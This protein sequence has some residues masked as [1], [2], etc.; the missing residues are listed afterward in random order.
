VLF[1]ALGLRRCC[2]RHSRSD[3]SDVPPCRLLAPSCA[4]LQVRTRVPPR[5]QTGGP[6]RW[7]A[8]WAAAAWDHPRAQSCPPRCPWAP[9]RAGDTAQRPTAAA[10]ATAAGA[11]A[12]AAGRRRRSS[13]RRRRRPPPRLL[14]RRSR[15]RNEAPSACLSCSPRSHLG[16]L[17]EG[18]PLLLALQHAL[19]L[20]TPN[21]PPC[22]VQAVRLLHAPAAQLPACAAPADSTTARLW[23][24]PPP[25]RPPPVPLHH[26]LPA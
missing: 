16:L 5:Q 17:P 2:S 1:A 24:P 12:A 11:A 25:P 20:R 21:P 14:P 3:A 18:P 7:G 10:G 6:W 8:P 19:L 13:S 26:H 15:Q 23:D 22:P 9:C 4:A